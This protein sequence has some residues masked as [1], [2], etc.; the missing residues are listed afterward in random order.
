MID[1]AYGELWFCIGMENVLG[2]EI[3]RW[4]IPYI[5]FLHRKSSV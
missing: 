4:L 1:P 2:K 5:L 3:L